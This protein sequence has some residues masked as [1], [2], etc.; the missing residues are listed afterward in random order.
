MSRGKT[1]R[2]VRALRKRGARDNPRMNAESKAKERA[3]ASATARRALRT[4]RGARETR[5]EK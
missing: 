2:H 4:V 3:K 1:E 5:E